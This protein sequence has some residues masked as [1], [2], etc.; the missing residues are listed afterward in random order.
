MIFSVLFP[1]LSIATA[2]YSAARF[3]LFTSGDCD[4]LARFTFNVLTPCLLFVS[5]ARSD[6]GLDEGLKFLAGYYLAA[7]GVYALAVVLGKHWFAYG[8]KEQSVFAMGSAYSNTTIVGIPIVAQALGEEALVPLFL[9]ISV[10]NLVLFTVG[11]IT[12]ERE[13]LST[14]TVVKTVGKLLRQL[15]SSPITASL[16]LGLTVNLAGIAIWNPLF[17]SIELLSQAAIPASL[18]VLGTSLRQYHVRDQVLPAIVMSVMKIVMLPA[19]VWFTLFVLFNVDPLWATVGVLGSAMPVGISA[20]VFANR[21][22]CAHAAVAA[23]S[24]ISAL[25]SIVTIS[26][27][28]WLLTGA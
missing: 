7:L 21:Y 2:G 13:H 16:I 24:L 14:D 17:D 19:A 15:M 4:T 27:L 8:H 10:Q 28:L 26:V 18:F 9:I 11:T 20:Y 1:V 3:R 12:G 25:S 6:I 5:T 23:G 22:Q